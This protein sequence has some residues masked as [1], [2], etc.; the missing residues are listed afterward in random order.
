M[1]RIWTEIYTM[2]S[3]GTL[4]TTLCSLANFSPKHGRENTALIY[5]YITDLYYCVP[6][7]EL[8]KSG[9]RVVADIS[10]AR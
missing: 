7:V 1:T 10:V 2:L 3:F 9:T 6:V 5:S 8:P 4:P